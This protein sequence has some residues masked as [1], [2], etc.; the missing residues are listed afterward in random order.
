MTEA[1]SSHNLAPQPPSREFL[2]GTEAVLSKPMDAP[3]DIDPRTVPAGCE[4][5]G[6]V[7][8]GVEESADSFAV[9][10]TKEGEYTLAGVLPSSPVAGSW[11]GRRLGPPSGLL[12]EGTRLYFGRAG[13]NPNHPKDVI[14]AGSLFMNM[15]KQKYG[16][17]VSRIHLSVSIEHD[18]VHITD[19]GRGGENSTNGTYLDRVP[20]VVSPEGNYVGPNLEIG[21]TM[22]TE[23]KEPRS[24]LRVSGP[25][26]VGSVA[27][28]G[29]NL[30]KYN[31]VDLRESGP[32]SD[33]EK[34]QIKSLSSL[35]GKNDSVDWLMNRVAELRANEQISNRVVIAA[36]VMAAAGSPTDRIKDDREERITQKRLS[37]MSGLTAFQLGEIKNMVADTRTSRSQ[38]YD[39]LVIESVLREQV[40]PIL[41]D[42]T[43]SEDYR[44]ALL[45]VLSGAGRASK[46]SQGVAELDRYMKFGKYKRVTVINPE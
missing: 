4:F 45:G 23:P 1:I 5:L 32:F 16:D 15:G 14:G 21:G 38:R 7:S 20:N 25:D 10:R 31:K 27:I 34:E 39:D 2:H 22:T 29:V 26:G 19:G 35:V 46:Y 11:D 30:S 43:I 3:A 18:G 40:D 8:M 42:T 41:Q 13:D 36:T 24:K 28:G 9:L 37:S 44:L 12:P 17:E 6:V 33:L